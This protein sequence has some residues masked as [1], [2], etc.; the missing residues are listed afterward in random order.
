MQASSTGSG[1]RIVRL[2]APAAA[3]IGLEVGVFSAST[4]I[5][6]RLGAVA[7]SG[8]QIALIMA[9]LTFMVPLGVAQATSVRVGNAIGRR[10]AEAAYVSGWSGVALSASFMS[11]SAIVLW[12]LPLPIVHIFT[13]DPEV[14]KVGVSLLAIAAVFQFFDGV[15]VTAIGALRGSGN[16]RIA[17]ITDLVGWW[18]IGLPLGAWLCFGRG[19]GVR[20]LWIGLSAGLISIGCVW[21]WPGAA[22]CSGCGGSWV[23]L[24]Q[25]SSSGCFR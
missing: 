7:V 4:L 21:P 19:W 22:E 14:A 13:Y 2:G 6:G 3:Q 11:C 17:M 9:S 16:T 10:D 20:G 12:T 15:Q 8:H 24:R 25:R 18:L 5:A 1:S 23:P